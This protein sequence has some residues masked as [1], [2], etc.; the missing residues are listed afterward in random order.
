MGIIEAFIAAVI[1]S[2]G[3]AIAERAVNE[4]VLDHDNDPCIGVGIEY[5]PHP[6]GDGRARPISSPCNNISDRALETYNDLA[7]G[8]LAVRD[9]LR[10]YSVDRVEDNAAAAQRPSDL[11]GVVPNARNCECARTKRSDLR[12]GVRATVLAVPAGGPVA[13]TKSD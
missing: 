12:A 3:S 11:S 8:H 1:I 2:G 10:T 9:T 13:S 7:Q 6:G 4:L 5:C